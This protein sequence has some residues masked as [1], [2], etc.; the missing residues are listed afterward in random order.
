MAVSNEV[1]PPAAS[2]PRAD[3]HRA[4]R[5]AQADARRSFVK[6]LGVYAT[7]VTL[8]ANALAARAKRIGPARMAAG[9]MAREASNLDTAARLLREAADRLAPPISDAQRSAIRAALAERWPEESPVEIDR[10]VTAV[11]DALQV[12]RGAR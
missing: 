6:L 2:V 3:R 9:R 8:Q 1:S 5:N 4:G 7:K 12:L 10:D 11:C